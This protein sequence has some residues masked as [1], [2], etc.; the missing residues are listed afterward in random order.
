MSTKTKTALILLI[1]LLWSVCEAQD[2]QKTDNQA[3]AINALNPVAPVIK[4]QMQPNY[5]I[6]YGGGE[7]IN[8]MTRIVVPYDGMY[9]PFFKSKSKK[10]SSMM[11]LEIP[12]VS[13][14]YDSA[15]PLN[16]TGLGDITISEVCVRK[17]SWGKAG[18]GPCLGFPTATN[19]VLGSEKWTAG[20][21]AVAVY[22]K[23]KHLM[24][25]VFMYQF[26]SYA[27]SSA[28]PDK[29]YMTVQPFIDV[30]FNKGYFIMVNPIC[31]F[32]WEQHNY[33]IPLALGFGKAFAKNL[34]AYIMPEYIIS[35][36]TR[37]S[38]V[39]QFNLNTMF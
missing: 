15:S 38:W 34:S 6:F 11:R 25:G 13:Q 36:P 37:K 31:T 30:I 22:N 29:N 32:D 12:V 27:G 18:I 19:P 26:F 20:L 8:L 39:I 10:Y 21:V 16:A 35:G 14:T 9:L 5:S 17:F 24:L 7:Q 3:A 28:R 1:S 23:H 2:K 33:T 4:F